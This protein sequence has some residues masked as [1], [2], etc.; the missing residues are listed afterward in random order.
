M[1]RVERGCTTSRKPGE[2]HAGSGAAQVIYGGTTVH[3]TPNM[4]VERT[5]HTTGFLPMRVSDR[6]WPAAHRG[7]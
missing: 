5:G 1:T 7:R 3:S 4:A 2:A 6:L